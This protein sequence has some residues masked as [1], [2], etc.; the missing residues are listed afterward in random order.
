MFGM[1]CVAKLAKHI[2][3]KC[4][5]EGLKHTNTLGNSIRC[6]S[7]E[8]KSILMRRANSELCMYVCMYICYV[9]MLSMYVC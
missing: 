7:H 9:S 1:F 4:A 2:R 8:L 3:F 5:L 6:A